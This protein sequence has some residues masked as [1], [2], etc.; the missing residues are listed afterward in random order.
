[1]NKESITFLMNL[2]ILAPML[3][4]PLVLAS[5][6]EMAKTWTFITSLIPF[7]MSVFLYINYLHDAATPDSSTGMVYYSSYKWL[8]VSGFDVNFTTG[9]DGISL[10]LVM[11][12]TLIFPI[13][14]FFSWGSVEKHEK[15]YY[16]LLLLLEVGVIGFF[17][18][19]DMLLFYLFFEMVLIPMYF[20]IGIWGGKDRIYASIKFFLYTLIGS[21]LMLV[22]II[23]M[24][25]HA[26]GAQFQFTT[27]YHRIIAACRPDAAGNFL[28]SLDA[29]KWLFWAFTASFAVK[30]PLFPVHTWLPDAHVQAPTAG[31]VI[32]A[33]V[34]L[35]MGSYGLIR[36]VLP[37]FP[38]A[39]VDYSGIM[40]FLAVVGIIYGGMAAM[41]QTDIKKLVA[42]SSVSHMGFIVLGIFSI[43]KEGTS[44][45]IIQMINHGVSTG[46]LFLLVGMIY[47]RRHSREIKDFQ[48]IAK[49]LPIFT[50]LFMLTTFSSVGLPGLNGF[51]GEFLVLMGSFNSTIISKAFGFFAAT[52]VIVA[53]VYLLWMFRR[54][55]FGELDKEENRKLVDLNGKEI[56]LLMPLI[57]LMFIMGLWANPFLK[58]INASSDAMLERA[59][60][61]P[62]EV[63]APAPT[64]PQ[65]APAAP[66]QMNM[67]TGGH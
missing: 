47:D 36:F 11:L 7:V 67:P 30:V 60:L 27:D 41:V 55:M 39:S 53:A 8:T 29:Q 3:G 17:L 35:K 54:V 19:L 64:A 28:I 23:Y 62:A 48:G 34:L 52:G 46:A 9:I 2:M 40:S 18:S 1:M 20:I 10:Y 22:A 63:V 42:Y 4:L 5:K 33:A 37:M 51:V 61:R 66:I 56:G 59:G 43:T 12:T 45:A 16:S 32:L 13:S 21:L 25:S 24:G 44:G 57:A 58:H 6:K 49:Q 26:G 65:P 50:L 31:S 15:S 14:I 38:A